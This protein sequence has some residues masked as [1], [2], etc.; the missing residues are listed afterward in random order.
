MDIIKNGTEFKELKKLYLKRIN[1]PLRVSKKISDMRKK[2][3]SIYRNFYLSTT[4]LKKQKEIEEYL[5]YQTMLKYKRQNF[6]K[7]TKIQF[8]DKININ[9]LYRNKSCTYTDNN[10]LYFNIIIRF[11][12]KFEYQP[13]LL[14]LK[15]RE[16]IKC[17]SITEPNTINVI[18]KFKNNNKKSNI[19]SYANIKQIKSTNITKEQ[20]KSKSSLTINKKNKNKNDNQN[21]KKSLN[22]NN[23]ILKLNDKNKIIKIKKSLNIK[24]KD[25]KIIIQSPQNKIMKKKMIIFNNNIK[26]FQRLEKI[27]SPIKRRK[28]DTSLYDNNIK[29]FNEQNSD[30]INILLAKLDKDEYKKAENINNIINVKKTSLKKNFSNEP[31]GHKR[32]FSSFYNSQKKSTDNIFFKRNNQNFSSIDNNDNNLS[33]NTN[34]IMNLYQSNKSAFKYLPILNRTF[35]A[36]MNLSARLKKNLKSF[37]KESKIRAIN[38]NKKTKNIVKKYFSQAESPTIKSTLRLTK[39]RYWPK[40][41]HQYIYEDKKGHINCKFSLNKKLKSPLIFVEEYNRMRNRRRRNNKKLISNIGF[42][43]TSKQDI[44]ENKIYKSNFGLFFNNN[45]AF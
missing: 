44:K 40:N 16:A 4:D 14:P 9:E 13:Y 2:F 37:K 43:I 18:K 25:N 33:K 42:G 8:E 38:S 32:L 22:K 15:K 26:Q 24:K 27:I 29:S 28:E 1:T 23:D 10:N 6:I 20:I 35:D 12:K 34:K 11:D 39:K 17:T 7:T 31:L 36:T 41:I 21:L 19:N 45:K 5:K 30:N 3:N